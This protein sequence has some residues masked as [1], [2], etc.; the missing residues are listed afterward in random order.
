MAM[1]RSLVCFNKNEIMIASETKKWNI[2]NTIKKGSCKIVFS[3]F[4]QIYT[5]KIPML[6][7]AAPY[8]LA[9]V[10]RALLAF[11]YAAINFGFTNRSKF[12]W[13]KTAKETLDVY[14]KILN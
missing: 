12:S 9:V 7:A 6:Q 2:A 14:K 10:N 1:F 13:R 3:K 11:L 8:I 5:A 4:K